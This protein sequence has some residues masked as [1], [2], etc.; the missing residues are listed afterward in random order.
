M[1][2]FNIL[3]HALQDL[4]EVDDASLRSGLTEVLTAVQNM[5]RNLENERAREAS[6]GTA[7]R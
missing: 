4:L 6:P 7:G 1:I 2:N 3:S 5:M